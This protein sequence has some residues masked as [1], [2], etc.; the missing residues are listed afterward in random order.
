MP[1]RPDESGMRCSMKKGKK[2]T[3]RVVAGRRDPY[4]E[5]EKQRVLLLVAS[6]MPRR[7]AAA[8]IGASTEALRLWVKQAREEGTMPS[9]REISCAIGPPATE[10]GEV[11]RAISSDSRYSPGDR[12][13]MSM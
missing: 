8:M 7:K 3:S 6:G 5:E 2:Q 10:E 11:A 4:S 1:S 9:Q 12:M 13:S